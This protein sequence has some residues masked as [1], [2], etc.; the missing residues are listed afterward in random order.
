MKQLRLFGEPVKKPTRAQRLEL[1]V[2]QR[3]WA[4][5]RCQFLERRSYLFMA[6]VSREGGDADMAREYIREHLPDVYHRHPDWFE[7]P[8][9][10]RIPE[11][12]P[13]PA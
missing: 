5:D 11:K 13:R 2:L 3:Q 8:L 10:H 4:N 7:R 6:G 12:P 9:T 1:Q